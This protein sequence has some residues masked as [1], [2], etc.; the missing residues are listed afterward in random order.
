MNATIRTRLARVAATI[1]VAAVAFGMLTA[2]SSAP[3][4]RP[5][6]DPQAVAS[7]L[8]ALDG[9][10][11]VV[12]QK[13]P[14]SFGD[15][16]TITADGQEIGEI[17]GEVIYLIGDTYTL[18]APDGS[19]VASE[20]EQF[21]VVTRKANLYDST[22]QI[23][24]ALDQQ[25]TLFMAKYSI[26]DGEGV[27]IGTAEQKLNWTMK[28]DVMSAS[29]SKDYQISKA[30]ISMGSKVTVDRLTTD[31]KISMLDALWVAVVASE[32]EDAQNED[33]NS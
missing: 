9:A 24:G 3:E 26:L 21:K 17:R 6:S 31:T 7:V 23:Y 16:W 32:V 8:E 27:A 19:I 13:S 28:F 10:D 12:A 11:Q 14:I 18:F 22:G 33:S 25:F 5:E 2:C 29:G 30:A 1:A 4:S 15:K 20:E